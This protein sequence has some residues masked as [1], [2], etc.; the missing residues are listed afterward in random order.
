MTTHRPRARLV[1]PGME[2]LEARR[3]LST[4]DFVSGLYTETLHRS[5]TGP[6]VTAWV[7]LIEQGH[8]RGEVAN[9]FWTSSAHLGFEVEAE[10][11][12]IV[13]RSADPQGLAAA[14]AFLASGGTPSA[15]DR[16]LIDSAEYQQSHASTTAFVQGLYTEVLH[17]SPDASGQATWVSAIDHGF[18]RDAAAQLFLSTQAHVGE[19]VNGLYEDTLHRG[20]DDVGRAA[21][22]TFLEDNPAR[23]NELAVLLLSS[24]EFE[25]EHASGHH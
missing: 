11:Q 21:G 22:M 12:S 4:S 25:A 1:N 9:L 13:H 7:N 18:S 17:R 20:A 24:G 6:E 3:V 14:T 10:Y 2:M 8:S 19:V 5:A 23:Y 16:I 15:L